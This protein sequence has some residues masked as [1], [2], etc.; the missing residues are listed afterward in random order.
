MSTAPDPSAAKANEETSDNLCDR[1]RSS[2]LLWM[3]QHADDV[4]IARSAIP[5]LAM[6][7]EE[8]SKIMWDDEAWHYNPPSSF[9]EQVRRER[10]AMYI[11]AL[12][13]INFCFWPLPGYE[14][15]Q[16]A[17]SLTG[18]ASQ[19]HADQEKSQDVVSGSFALSAKNLSSLTPELMT[20]LF[21]KHGKENVV[22]PD[23]ETRCRLLNQVG[24]VLLRHFNGSAWTLIQFANGSA[25]RLVQLLNGFFEGF[26]DHQ[27]EM[28]FLKRAQICVGDW[29]AALELKLSDLSELT[30]FADYRV[31]QL[32]RHFGILE[33]SQQ[34]AQKVDLK[35]DLVVNSSEELSIR[36]ATVVAVEWIV[37]ELRVQAPSKEWTAV[38]TDWYLWQ[39]GERMQNN[40]E[41]LPHHRVKTIYY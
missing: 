33:Y 31:P 5:P 2:C 27:G 7:I 17:C 41:L 26:R 37:Q 32:L 19:D 23:I 30:T 9:G 25:V 28:F 10:I 39:V 11:L 6:R 38:E 35:E 14:Y 24:N 1:V 4:T 22:P 36:A 34:L 16:L 13:A 20:D 18:I 15:D 8:Q 21:A 3:Q 40:G 12:D 29:N